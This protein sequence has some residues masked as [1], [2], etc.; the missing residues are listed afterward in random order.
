M[1]RAILT[2]NGYPADYLDT[3]YACAACSDTGFVSGR[4]CAC[5]QREI[6]NVAAEAFRQ[7]S[8]L[9]LTS[10]DS[11]SLSY[12]RDLP[13]EKYEAMVR[14]FQYC[15]TYAEQFQPG[16]SG[17]MLIFGSTG[18]GKTHLSLAIASVLIASGYTVIYDSAGAL[19]HKLE[20]EHFGRGSA[21]EDTLDTLRSCDLLIIDDFGTEFETSF[22]RSQIY[23]IL[24]SRMN[25]G[26]AVIV[27]TNLTPEEIGSR[28]GDRVLSRLITGRI[29]EF[30]GKDIRLQKRTGGST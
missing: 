3:H 16:H 19:L 26:R 20:Q 15:K 30:Y 24:N 14:S 5:L 21:E 4:R 17:S 13:K 1:L 25:A 9:T 18:I 11:F 10:F 22:T 2:A 12:Y 6:T 23:T 29:M 27:N 28:Y 7:E 8:Q